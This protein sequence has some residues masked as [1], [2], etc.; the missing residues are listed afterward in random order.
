MKAQ[1]LKFKLS[2]S[3]YYYLIRRQ[4]IDRIKDMKNEHYKTKI[5]DLIAFTIKRLKRWQTFLVYLWELKY[6]RN[7]IV[8][9]SFLVSVYSI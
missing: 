4:V 8:K 6:K 5:Y 2:L 9:V 7:K 1:N 3:S